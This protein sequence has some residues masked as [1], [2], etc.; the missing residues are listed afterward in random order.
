MRY[1]ITESKAHQRVGFFCYCTYYNGLV[2]DV[3]IYNR[4]LSRDEI[5]ALAGL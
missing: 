3:R 1:L 5:A 4:A 2:D